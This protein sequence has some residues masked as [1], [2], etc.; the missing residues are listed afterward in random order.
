MGST[1]HK[2]YLEEVKDFANLALPLSMSRIIY[3]LTPFM[4]TFFMAK[5]GEN[6]LAAL[7]IGSRVFVTVYIFIIG[8][9]SS[10]S[11]LISHHYGAQNY[12]G[13]TI[14]VSQGI[15]LSIITVI[16]LSLFLYSITLFLRHTKINHEVLFLAISYLHTSILCIFPAQLLEV[17]DR[18]LIGIGETRI[19]LAISVLQVPFEILAMYVFVYGKLGVPKLGIAG[20]P[21]SSFIVCLLASISIGIYLFFAKEGRKYFRKKYFW[22][23]NK[24]YLFE[25][26]R[27]GIPIALT[28][29]IEVV[30]LVIMVFMVGYFG[31][32]QLAAYQIVWQYFVVVIII[33]FGFS[34][35]IAIRVGHEVGRK[36]KKGV[37]L[38]VKT[39]FVFS[40]IIML[41]VAICF[42]LLR[43]KMIAFDINIHQK[44]FSE[45]IKYAKLYFVI[46]SIWLIFDYLRIFTT[47]A[48]RGLKDTKYPMFVSSIGIFGIGVAMSYIF[49][50]VLKFA[51]A[52]VWLGM[53]CGIFFSALV[54]GIRLRKQLQVLNPVDIL[55]IDKNRI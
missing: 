37:K 44:S 47:G 8:L 1:S 7:A 6:Q 5:F 45:L 28:R 46:I 50:F 18:F 32:N 12:D 21:F 43:Q 52:G 55:K 17:F 26:I 23:F 51:S 41:I 2:T 30:A 13:V 27:V 31:K 35:T 20:I 14:T 53:I 29:T 40:L 10:I 34:E 36:N 48:L 39:G 33:A 15:F 22:K 42:L 54:L 49:G 16:P 25:L 24:T 19:V 3:I 38:A 4:A 9:F 11:I